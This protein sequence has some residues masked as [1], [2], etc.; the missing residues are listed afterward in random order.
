MEFA[1]DNANDAQLAALAVGSETLS[2]VFASTT[3]SLSLIHILEIR[4]TEEKS[5]CC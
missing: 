3:Y 2:P 4:G 1:A 5:G